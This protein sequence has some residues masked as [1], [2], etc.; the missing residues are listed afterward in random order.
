MDL[1]VTDPNGEKC[2]YGHKDTYQGG[3]MSDDFTGGYGPEEFSLRV[4]KA[5]KYVV[6][7]N[8][9]GDRATSV[10]GPTTLQL[11]LTTGFGTPTQ[12]ERLVTLRLKAQSETV[13]VG[14][15]VVD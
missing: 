12:T 13:L 7:V 11:R 4:P 9:Y 1:W 6:Q 14:E 15:F 2:F 5:G 3:H 10:N 8:Y